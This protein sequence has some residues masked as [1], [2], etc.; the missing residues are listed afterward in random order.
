[1]T[2]S[3]RERKGISEKVITKDYDL[4]KIAA[5]VKSRIEIFPDIAEQIDFFEAVPEYDTAMYCHKKMK[6]NEENSLEVLKKFFRF[7]K[8][9]KTIVMMHCLR[10]LRVMLMR[11]V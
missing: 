9:R 3:M 8:H 5:L 1:M 6:T 7:W 2:S 4:K 10:F 11:R